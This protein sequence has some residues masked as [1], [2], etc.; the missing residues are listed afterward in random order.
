MPYGPPPGD[1][2]PYSSGGA[3][4]A[5]P[6]PPPGQP[7]YGYPSAPPPEQPYGYPQQAAG[8]GYGY[9]QQGPAD[10]LTCRFCGGY[11]AVNATVRGHQGLILAYRMLRMTGP[12]C[13]TCGTATVRDMSARTL[14]QG[15]WSLVSWLLT[16]IT[17]LANLVPHN[18][19]QRLQPPVPGSHGPQLDP[20]VP[21]TRRPHIAMLLVPVSL[22]VTLVLA[23]TGVLGPGKHGTGT[24]P[25]I[26]A[27][28]PSASSFSYTPAPPP[29]F[30]SPTFTMPAVPSITLPPVTT[31][32]DPADAPDSVDTAKAGDCLRNENGPAGETTDTHPKVSVL[33][34]TDT[35]AQY[36][37]IY[38]YPATSDEKVCEK[39]P[40]SDSWYT[41]TYTN[42]PALN[43]VL[44][45]KKLK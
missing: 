32:S 12:F 13:R 18:R 39:Q 14:V 36:K 26:A 10:G 2:N 8:Y 4:G 35:K 29:A 30:P 44:C 9:P 5:P 16:P 31:P 28:S 43:Y 38:K 1:G 6:P 41:R 33:P 7:G 20:G 25:I 11:P 45:L 42:F 21:L 37:V 40:K 24:D 15:W 27:P 19:F 3:Y 17:L 34:C 23:S 22:A